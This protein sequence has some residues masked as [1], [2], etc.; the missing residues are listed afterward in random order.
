MNKNDVQIYRIVAEM[1]KELSRIMSFWGNK[2]VD[3]TFGG[4]YGQ[5]NSYGKVVEKASKGAILNARILWSFSAVYNYTRNNTILTLAHRAYNYLIQ[6][7]IDTQNGGLFWEVDFEGKPINTRKQ[8]YVQGFG[9][10]ALSE[11]YRASGL[12]E[13]LNYAKELY[14]ILENHFKDKKGNGYI[15]ALAMDWKPLDDMRLSPKDY[16]SPKSMNTHLHILEPYTNLYRVWKNENLKQNILSLVA[17]FQRKI[18]DSNSGRF[19]LFFGMDW[20]VESSIVSFGHDIEGAWLIHEAAI[21]IGDQKVIKSAQR[22][23]LR[24][25]EC[26]LKEGFAYDG[27][28][29]YEAESGHIDTDRHWWVQ[30]E[31]MVG[32]TDAWEMTQN[33][34]YLN[35]ALTVWKFIKQHIIDNKNGEWFWSINDKMK[36]NLKEDKTGFWKCPYHNTRALIEMIQRLKKG[37]TIKQ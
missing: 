12:K 25:V 18:I 6:H 36:P 4:F 2:A 1:E 5:I 15:E 9:I 31:A 24:L 20:T 3:E 33:E 35:R 27:S 17:L 11:Y 21:E 8:A 19:N 34:D 32:L 29:L 30:A 14:D 22:T 26:T 28:L 10:Y 13:S 7:F 23:A 16:N 37:K